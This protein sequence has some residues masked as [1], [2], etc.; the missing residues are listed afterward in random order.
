MRVPARLANVKPTRR[1]VT[2]SLCNDAVAEPLPN[3]D[4]ETLD[5]RPAV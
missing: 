2:K 1:V 5:T 3:C 4:L